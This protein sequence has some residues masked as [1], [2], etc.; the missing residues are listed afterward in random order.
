LRIPT[1]GETG[2]VIIPP[3]EVRNEINMWRRVYHAY[4]ST[5]TPH[6]TIIYP[7]IPIGVWDTNRWA[8]F[9]ATRGIYPF[10]I[11]LHELGTFVHDES[12]LWLK[13]EDGK[14]LAKIRARMQDLFSK[15]IPTSSLAYVPHM[16]IGLFD[17]VEDLWKARK[18]VQKQFKPMHFTVD[19]AIYAIFEQEGWRIHDH[20]SFTD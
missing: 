1:P 9:N 12:V 3:P 10:D 15:Q 17:S 8:I 20:I 18:T 5:I 7:F 13:P 6:I 16:T 14:N 19:K 11:K 4:E 2:L